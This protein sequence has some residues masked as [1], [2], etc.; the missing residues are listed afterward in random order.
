M[1][2]VMSPHIYLNNKNKNA[3]T[4]RILG[5]ETIPPEKYSKTCYHSIQNDPGT[6]CHGTVHLQGLPNWKFPFDSVI[7]APK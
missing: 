1:E 2:M 7:S 3:P 4:C 6:N 5:T